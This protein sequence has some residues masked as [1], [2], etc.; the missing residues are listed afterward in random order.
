MRMKEGMKI[1][2]HMIIFNTLICQF[3]GMHVKIDDKDK[4]VNLLCTL[5]NSW[6][7]VFSSINLS[8]TDTL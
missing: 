8:T 7:Q 6:V 2:Y 3:S 5:L 4:A 1:E